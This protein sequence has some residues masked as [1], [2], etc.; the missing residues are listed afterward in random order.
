MT[1]IKG[2]HTVWFNATRYAVYVA[3]SQGNRN[4]SHG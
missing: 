3:Y 1:I 2:E 4:E